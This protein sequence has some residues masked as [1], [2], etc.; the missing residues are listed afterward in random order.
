MINFAPHKNV[1]EV[2]IAAFA[3]QVGAALKAY[4]IK[5][6]GGDTVAAPD[7]AMFSLTLIGEVASGGMV[8]RAGA[9]IGG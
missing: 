9:K 5:L 2:W 3:E 4:N 8:Q 7:Q 1:S 6:L